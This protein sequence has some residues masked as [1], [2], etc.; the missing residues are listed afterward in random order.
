MVIDHSHTVLSELGYRLREKLL[1]LARG[2]LCGIVEYLDA[3]STSVTTLLVS[4]EADLES[5]AARV[6]KIICELS[7]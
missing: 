5:V 3:T 2:E 4:H 7:T 6:S 1:I